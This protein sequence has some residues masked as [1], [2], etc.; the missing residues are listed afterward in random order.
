[1]KKKA[2]QSGSDEID[3]KLRTAVEAGD[4]NETCKLVTGRLFTLPPAFGESPR[5]KFD[6]VI[7]AAVMNNRDP[8]ALSVSVIQRIASVQ[9]A[10]M[11]RAEYVTLA[12]IERADR[13]SDDSRWGS[14]PLDVVE[15]HLPRLSRLQSTVMATLRVLRSL[16]KAQNNEPPDA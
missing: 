11:H 12:A 2:V 5:V 16:E 10:L 9:I 8:T 14:L 15:E 4:V 6:K 13:V 7:R 3:D 1:M